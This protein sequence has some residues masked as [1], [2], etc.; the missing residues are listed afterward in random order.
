VCQTYDLPV[1]PL[2]AQAPVWTKLCEGCSTFA[3]VK[4]CAH[5]GTS[6]FCG[7]RCQRKTWKYHKKYV[8]AKAPAPA[9]ALGEGGK[10]A[11]GEGEGDVDTL[12]AGVD[13]VGVSDS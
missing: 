12:A 4:R 11:K 6:Y 3:N 1:E 10:G 13:R 5:C 2:P 9:P 7:R 8:P